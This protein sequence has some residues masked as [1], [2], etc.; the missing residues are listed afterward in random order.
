M[1]TIFFSDF[2][3]DIVKVGVTVFQTDNVGELF[4]LE[5][6]FCFVMMF[7]DLPFYDALTHWRI[8]FLFLCCQ[9]CWLTS[10]R[11]RERDQE[12]QMFFLELCG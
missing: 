5:N 4:F 8:W 12:V 1:K 6:C 7:H 2:K 10:F 11:E 9:Y 3:K